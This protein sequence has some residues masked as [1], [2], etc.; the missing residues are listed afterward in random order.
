MTRASID[1]PV[2]AD[3]CKAV[4]IAAVMKIVAKPPPVDGEIPRLARARIAGSAIAA[5]FARFADCPASAGVPSHNGL[6]VPPPALAAIDI[7]ELDDRRT[8]NREHAP[9]TTVKRLR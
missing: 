7:G 3:R 5:R 1:V 2:D 9:A 4:R 8:I 6:E